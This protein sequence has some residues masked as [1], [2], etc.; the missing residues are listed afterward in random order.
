MRFE[1]VCPAVQR[2]SRF[3]PI[4]FLTL[5]SMKH[6]QPRLTGRRGSCGAAPIRSGGLSLRLPVT[7]A[8][9]SAKIAARSHGDQAKSV[10]AFAYTLSFILHAGVHC[11]RRSDSALDREEPVE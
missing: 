8:T 4:V 2:V 1:P 7:T 5:S 10:V 6:G 11:M 9:L 3:N